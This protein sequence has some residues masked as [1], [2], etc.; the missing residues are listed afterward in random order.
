MVH[1]GRGYCVMVGNEDS[2]VHIELD[3]ITINH[4]PF[5][6]SPLVSSISFWLIVPFS[7]AWLHNLRSDSPT[8]KHSLY[9]IGCTQSVFNALWS[10]LILILL[11]GGVSP[12]FAWWVSFHFITLHRG[13]Q[14]SHRVVTII[15]TTL[16]CRLL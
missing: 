1:L 13:T 14:T 3:P 4:T 9:V 7:R 12:P 5:V 2:T 16:L 8:E 10:S 11:T 15:R 6:V